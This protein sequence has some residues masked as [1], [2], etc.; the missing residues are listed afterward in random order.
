MSIYD[1]W[2]TSPR[3]NHAANY[4]NSEMDRMT[5]DEMIEFAEL[6]ELI[7]DDTIF[8]S[9]SELE[10]KLFEHLMEEYYENF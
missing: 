10:E 2:K 6:W 8:F 9:M 3:E 1:N 5:L 4:A 7:P